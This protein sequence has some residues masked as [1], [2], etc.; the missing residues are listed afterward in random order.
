[1]KILYLNFDRGIPVLGDKGASVH[2]REFV[3][4]AAD[5]GHE[6]TVICARLGAGNA[7]PPAEIVELAPQQDTSATRMLAESLQIDATGLDAT[8]VSGELAKLIYDQSAAERVMA[9]LQEQCFRPDF[10]YE[11]HTLFSSAGIDIARRIGCP[12][13]L[14]VNAPLAEEQKR[15]RGLRLESIARRMEAN[16]FEAADSIIAVSEAVGDYV[17]SLLTDDEQRVHIVPNG[18][19][20]RRFAAGQ[21]NRE[22]VR[23]RLGVDAKTG[24]IGFVGSFKSWHGTDFLFEIYRSIAPMRNVHLLAV[25]D[26]P[27]WGELYGKVAS[28]SCRDTVTL[29]GRVPHA[30]IPAWT[31]ACDVVVAPY[32]AA[33]DFYF[34]PLKVI[35]ALACARPVV[36]P[37]IG[38]LVELIEDGRT[39]L[40]YQ[41]DDAQDCTKAITTLLDDPER[42]VAM[43]AAAQESVGARGWDRIVMRVLE[44]ADAARM[45]EAA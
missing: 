32:H 45:G 30:E 4:A 14:E 13:I 7:K 17:Q 2:V 44:L 21:L 16:S 12:R 34:S 42:R 8:L 5:L 43:G 35:E 27:R 1:M 18:V 25:G 19:D 23:S 36:A 29:T 31:A 39:G 20:L 9:V 3:R 6:V 22:E 33:V 24:I 41:P 26:G 10:I 40:L 11:R 38:Q 28:S 37:R 15:F